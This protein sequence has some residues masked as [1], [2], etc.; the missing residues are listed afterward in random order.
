MCVFCCAGIH[1]TNEV[2]LVAVVKEV[3]SSEPVLEVVCVWLTEAVNQSRLG[4]NE[5]DLVNWTPRERANESTICSCYCRNN[6]SQINFC[7]LH[8]R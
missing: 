4:V 7:D 8:A 1:N 3:G 5:D 6:R 2:Q